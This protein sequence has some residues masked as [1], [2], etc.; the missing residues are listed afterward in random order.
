MQFDNMVEVYLETE[1]SIELRTPTFM[2]QNVPDARIRGLELMT[3]VDWDFAPNWKLGINGGVT[4]LDPR[5]LNGR[6]DWNGDDS[7]SAI[8]DAVLLIITNQP[9]PEG[10]RIPADNPSFLKYR[11]R[12]MVRNSLDLRYRNV[13]LTTFMRYDSEI[14]NVDKL[15]LIEELFPGTRYFRDKRRGLG[16]LQFDLILGMDF[17]GKTPDAS[18]TTLSLIVNNVFNAELAYQPGVLAP[19]RQFGLQF[20]V[21]L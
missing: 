19:Q 13:T 16:N 17:P 8:L 4:F 5:D 9:K 7:V 15:F 18:R 21:W 6:K 2:A 20:K 1:K 14:I 11:S 3:Q 12:W 10:F